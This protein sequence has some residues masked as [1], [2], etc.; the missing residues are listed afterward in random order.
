MD[1]I[2]ALIGSLTGTGQMSMRAKELRSR[3]L[4]VLEDIFRSCKFITRPEMLSWGSGMGQRIRK[5]LKIQ[6]LGPDNLWTDFC[7][8][9]RRDHKEKVWSAITAI[10]KKVKGK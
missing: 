4:L 9:F 5:K 2:A 7:N 10:G 3:S 6:G 8:Q 1:D